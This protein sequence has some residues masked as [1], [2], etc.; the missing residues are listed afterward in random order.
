MDAK[1]ITIVSGLPRS[2]TS[3]MMQ[4][5]EAGGIP[6]LTDNIRKKDEDNPKG[7]YEYELVKKTK[8][9]PSWVPGAQGKVVKVIYSLIYDLPSGFDYRIV[10]MERN[11]DEVL[12]SQKTMLERSNKEGAN[13]SDEKLTEVFKAQLAKFDAWIASRKEFH[14]LKINHRDMIT[15]P[16]PQCERVN[17]FLDGILD[18]EKAMEAVDPALYRKR[19]DNR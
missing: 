4:V 2:G 18:L 5:L 19:K 17:H 16:R 15:S 6:V 7:Y 9:D 12:A 3:M 14:M 11:L 10:F 13:V 1:F 8:Q